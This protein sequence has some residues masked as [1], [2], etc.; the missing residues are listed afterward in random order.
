M[1][2]EFLIPLA[3]A[4][5]YSL[6]AWW[7][8]GALGTFSPDEVE[9]MKGAAASRPFRWRMLCGWFGPWWGGWSAYIML[10]LSVPL[11]GALALSW[12][13]GLRE[14]MWAQLL[15][16]GT[17]GVWRFCL[18]HP[19]LV[20]PWVISLSLLGALVLRQDSPWG[21][22]ILL[23]LALVSEKAGLL[24]AV[25]SGNPL[26]LIASVA[27]L[28][29]RAWIGP[30]PAAHRERLQRTLEDPLREVRRRKRGKWFRWD[31][32]AGSWI[33]VLGA[34][35]MGMPGYSPTYLGASLLA[36]GV[37]IGWLFIANDYARLL[38]HAAPML[39][40]GAGAWVA[41][42]PLGCAL[43]LVLGHY[44]TPGGWVG[45]WGE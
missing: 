28:A 40:L 4:L 20:D 35:L 32:M 8:R 43:L 45:D 18:Q 3:V 19:W 15:W 2:G 12:D 17:L 24:A 30:G 11:V 23:P 7:D 44:L 29:P 39:A 25:M 37:C 38:H 33:V 1:P 6:L 31:L 5:G 27:W 26:G 13:F 21:L 36:L 14:A 22:L 16:I 42:L 41:Q 10:P 34:W 9:Y